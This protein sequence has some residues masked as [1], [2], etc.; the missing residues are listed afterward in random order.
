MEEQYFYKFLATK[1]D[2]KFIEYMYGQITIRDIINLLDIV[3]INGSLFT[4]K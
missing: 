4:K 2:K 1:A 3:G